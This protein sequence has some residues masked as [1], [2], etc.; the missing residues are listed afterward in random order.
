M[1]DLTQLMENLFLISKVIPEGNYLKM[2][3]NMKKIHDT[4]KQ[5]PAP[6]LRVPFQPVFTV[7]DDDD[8][9][10]WANQ[11]TERSYLTERLDLRKRELKSLR[12]RKNITEVVKQAAIKEYADQMN[13]HLRTYS[14]E[15]LRAK[16]FRVHN[17]RA[18]YK[19][20]IDRHNLVTRGMQRDIEDEI[21]E[22]TEQLRSF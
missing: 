15:E 5:Q 12:I 13:I 18:F 16:G 11:Q 4:L 7:P 6:V 22:I 20:Y 9:D 14:I 8:D 21:L 1:D 3:D 2:C 17:E 19:S 10:D